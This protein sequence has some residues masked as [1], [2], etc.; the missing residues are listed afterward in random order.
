MLPTSSGQ[1]MTGAGLGTAHKG[2]PIDAQEPSDAKAPPGLP[3]AVVAQKLLPAS[4]TIDVPLAMA[5]VGLGIVI[6]AAPS[7]VPGLVPTTG[8]LPMM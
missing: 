7:S 6:L 2:A 1:L 3:R 5:I 4:A 8:H